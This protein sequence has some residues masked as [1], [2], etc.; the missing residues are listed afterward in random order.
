MGLLSS[1]KSLISGNLGSIIGAGAS[2]L[3]QKSANEATGASTAK[4]MAF[5]KYMSDTAHQREVIDL[6]KAGLNPILSAKYGGASTPGGASYKAENEVTP[7]VNSAVALSANK[8]QVELLKAQVEKTRAE[9]ANVQAETPYIPQQRHWTIEKTI[10][11][12][13][14]TLQEKILTG[15]K[16]NESEL[17][18]IAQK[19]GNKKARAELLAVE[20]KRML[21]AWFNKWMSGLSDDIESGAARNSA[22]SLLENIR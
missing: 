3:G 15:N 6:K 1:A 9:T 18:Q 11:E 14:R 20:N 2:F 16:V 5:Q 17:T 19:I 4:Q 8:A 22:K 12:A 10:A 13:Q 21:H 7:A